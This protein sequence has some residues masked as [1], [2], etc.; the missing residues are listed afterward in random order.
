M[1]VLT[2]RFPSAVCYEQDYAAWAVQTASA[3]RAGRMSDLDWSAIAEELD[4]M[5]KRERRAL[6]SYLRNLLMHLLKWEYQPERRS[7]SWELTIDQARREI[8]DILT[9]SPSLRVE[10]DAVMVKEYPRARRDAA[11]ETG[12][13][14]ARLPEVCPYPVERILEDGHYPEGDG[15]ER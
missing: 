3:I 10:L 15:R 5:G 13:P 4:D 7:T 8:E 12:Q 2:K 1:S 9:D 11:K 14:L 6:G